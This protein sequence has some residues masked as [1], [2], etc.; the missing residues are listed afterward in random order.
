[1]GQRAYHRQV[2]TDEQ[3]AQATACLEFTQQGN[4]LFLHAA[5]QCRGR[6]IQHQQSGLEDQGARQGN[7][8]TLAAGE[9]VG[10]AIGT[11]RGQFDFLQHL[12]HTLANL[13]FAERWM[14]KAQT[15]TDDVR[16][17]HA[18]RQRAV[19]ILEDDLHLTA[20]QAQR[21]AIQRIDAFVLEVDLALGGLQLQERQGECRLAGPRFP[22]HAERLAAGQ[23]QIQRMN[24]D[25]VRGALLEQLLAASEAHLQL[26]RGENRCRG[27]LGTQVAGEAF[28]FGGQQLAG[29][30]GLW[31]IEYLVDA[32]L[33][34]AFPVAHHDHAVGMTAHQIEVM[35]DQDHRHA[36]VAA[37]AIQQL[38]Y[39][40]LHGDI[41]R[42]GRLIGDQQ[43]WLIGHRHGDHHALALPAGE[44]VWPGV[45]QLLG[46]RQLHLAEQFQHALAGGIAAQSLLEAQAFTD[47][48]ADTRQR[49]E[50]G[51]RLLE[52]ETD[53][54]AAHPLPLAWRQ[55]GE[56]Q[57]LA[58]RPREFALPGDMGMPRQQAKTRQQADGLARPGLADD[59]QTFPPSDL[60]GKM[61]DDGCL[62]EADAEIVES[63]H[64][65]SGAGVVRR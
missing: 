11:Y 36:L 49:V 45:D 21:V 58:V 33:L 41:Q 6:L 1:M 12:R 9:L 29:I 44:L 63:Q 51:H 2:M 59:G 8:L 7:P 43:R 46:T 55:G 24:G 22:D 20:T 47:L 13:V 39:L 48:F 42:R 5:V 52:H 25:E 62:A 16:H 28:G 30:I 57:R 19:W 61:P 23:C 50:R 34:D 37:Q 32:P 31:R 4:Q 3:I 40:L 35:A 27:V 26:A 14:M 65:G 10:I 56:I 15:F 60:K 18:W 38:E 17:R 53:L 54:A 64:A